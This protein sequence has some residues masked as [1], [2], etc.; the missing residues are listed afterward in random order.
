MLILIKEKFEEW[1]HKINIRK[2]Q[3]SQIPRIKKEIIFLEKLLKHA[4]SLVKKEKHQ[5]KNK[6]VKQKLQKKLK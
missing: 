3:F 1:L 4:H 6:Q 5:I 2:H